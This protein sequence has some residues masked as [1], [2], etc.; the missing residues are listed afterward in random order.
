MFKNIFCVYD[1]LKEKWNM[2]VFSV[3]WEE[4]VFSKEIPYTRVHGQEGPHP[5]SALRSFL[6][7]SLKEVERST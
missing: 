5:S 4:S 3:W 1:F 7:L 6:R 2:S